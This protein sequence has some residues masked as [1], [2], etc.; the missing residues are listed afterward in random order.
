LRPVTFP[1]RG[2]GIAGTVIFSISM[3][4]GRLIIALAALPIALSQSLSDNA[5]GQTPVVA[6]AESKNSK[7]DRAKFRVIVDVGHTVDEPGAISA[8]GVSEYEFN[9]RL[10]LQ[11]ERKLLDAGFSKTLLLVTG[12]LAIP[13]L[14]Q[15]V[16]TANKLAANLFL[17]IHHDSVPDAFLENWEF[18]GKPNHFSD[19]FKGHSIFVSYEN[20]NRNASVL[21]G[22]LLGKE[23][24]ARGLNYTPH[25]TEAIM[26]T[27]RRA[28][29]DADVG[30]YRFDELYVLRATQ[31]PAVLLE[32]G[33]I[34]NR[35][36]ELQMNTEERRSLIAGA[37]LDAVENFCALRG[38]R[39]SMPLAQ[40]ADGPAKQPQPKAPARNE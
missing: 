29:L 23:L 18:E 11:I 5:A 13:G 27:R 39:I 10:T 19:R 4:R 7:C 34:I 28:L 33:S 3:I 22:Q 40:G 32:A 17:S 25:Y 24:K 31:I 20:S 2:Y 14:V 9:L 15:R 21:F 35:D 1:Y 26:G 30:V 12:G 6:S 8:R 16:A 38:P 37:V 36:E